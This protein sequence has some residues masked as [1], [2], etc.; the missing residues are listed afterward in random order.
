MPATPHVLVPRPEELDVEFYR[1]TV[2]SDRLCT[3]VVM[4]D[5]AR[6]RFDHVGFNSFGS[7]A[8]NVFVAKASGLVK[9]FGDNV[10]AW[11]EFTRGGTPKEISTAQRMKLEY[12]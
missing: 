11:R 8:M 4:K 9:D 6:L 7:T 2:A 12:F 5:G 1:A 10:A 3:D